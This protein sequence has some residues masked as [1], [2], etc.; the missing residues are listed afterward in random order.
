MVVG[1]TLNITQMHTCQEHN[2]TYTYYKQERISRSN[3]ERE[4]FYDDIVKDS[5]YA[6]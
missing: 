2:Q 3:S 5:A 4:R 6:H 1:T